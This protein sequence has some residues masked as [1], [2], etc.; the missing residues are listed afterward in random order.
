MTITIRTKLLKN[1]SQSLY[2]D[3]YHRGQRN[4]KFLNL[5]LIPE[6]SE[7]AKLLN[8]NALRKAYE[9]KAK[10][11]LGIGVPTKKHSETASV[12]LD[13]WLYTYA[14]NFDNRNA[15]SATT[16]QQTRLVSGIIREYLAS[17][18]KE[19]MCIA[20]FRRDEMSGFLRF[21]REYVGQR[22]HRLSESTLSTYQ[23]RTV[24]I[25]SSA[26]QEGIITVNPIKMVAGRER[27]H[28]PTLC[29]EYLTVDEVARVAAVS[30]SNQQV[31]QAFLFACLTGLRLSDLRALRWSDIKQI[32]GHSVVMLEQHKTKRI[33]I[34]PVCKTAQTFL[35]AMT[36][37]DE[38][39]FHLPRKTWLRNALI[40]ILRAAGID[41][42]I[43]FH[44]SR[45][46]FG[47]L[48]TAACRDLKVVSSMLGHQS[49][50]NTQIYADVMIDSKQNAISKL[51]KIMGKDSSL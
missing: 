34:V 42:H 29:K 26:V 23:Q 51:S 36:P 28:K 48:A 2:L 35:P 3:I 7:T 46:T 17:I 6:V 8:A 1:G 21:L 16:K 19:Q 32:N 20:D 31:R 18:K 40:R 41:K 43:T 24:A 38:H 30:V 50:R 33:V 22:G 11:V 5:Y 25:F 9:L 49:I 44:S 14:K 27:I 47:T 4:Y 37:G 13:E 12:T 15:V 39:V 10:A 45:H